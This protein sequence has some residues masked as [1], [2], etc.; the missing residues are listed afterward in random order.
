MKTYPM[1]SFRCDTKLHKSIRQEAKRRNMTV[2]A[3]IKEALEQHVTT[4]H[5]ESTPIVD[6]KTTFRV[7]VW[8]SGIYE[9]I[10]QASN[11]EE[12][13]TIVEDSGFQIDYKR[14]EREVDWDYES[15]EIGDIEHIENASL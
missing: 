8:I 5:Q 15:F 2:S 10:A 4:T 9:F 13:A 6:S 11:A 7:P 12:A 14:L 1:L 3:F